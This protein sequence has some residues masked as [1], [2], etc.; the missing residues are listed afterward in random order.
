MLTFFWQKKLSYHRG[1]RG[2]N[3][4]TNPTVEEVS[5]SYAGVARSRSESSSLF[6]SA[7]PPPPP[8]PPPVWPSGSATRQRVGHGSTFNLNPFLGQN[9]THTLARTRT[10]P[11]PPMNVSAKRGVVARPSGITSCIFIALPLRM[12]QP[13]PWGLGFRVQGSGFAV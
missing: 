1:G 6:A 5:S 7:P 8:P 4:S 11:P 10:Q 2:V 13:E 9:G 12:Y 3:K